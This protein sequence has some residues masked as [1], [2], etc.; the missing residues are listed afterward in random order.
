M[1]LS[2]TILLSCTLCASFLRHTS[3]TAPRLD[4]CAESA[5]CRCC[6]GCG[7]G[8]FNEEDGTLELMAEVVERGSMVL[9]SDFS[10]KALIADW[11]VLCLSLQ[12]PPMLDSAMST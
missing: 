11:T 6:G 3:V 9:V 8:G 10:V 2:P 12:C 4:T 7:S 1:L 5:A